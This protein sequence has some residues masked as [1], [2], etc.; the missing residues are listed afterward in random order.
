MSEKPMLEKYDNLADRITGGISEFFKKNILVLALAL[1]AGIYVNG[2]DITN[3]T[4]GIDEELFF[5]SGHFG[6]E[7]LTLDRWGIYLLSRIIPMVWYPF[8]SQLIGI[9]FMILAAILIV[10]KYDKITTSAK[11][12]FCILIAT[13]PIFAYM[14][15]FSIQIAYFGIGVFITV[16]SYRIYCNVI[17]GGGSK[18]YLIPALACM[19]LAVGVYQ[20]FI[21]LFL[22]PLAIDNFIKFINNKITIKQIIIITAYA[23][24]FLLVAIMFNYLIVKILAFQSNGYTSH[25]LYWV[26]RSVIINLGEVF[27]QMYRMMIGIA[28]YPTLTFVATI[29]LFLSIPHIMRIQGDK[30]FK[31]FLRIFFMIFLFAFSGSALA[32]AMGGEL[33]TRVQTS[34]TFFFAGSIFIYY[35]VGSKIE[36]LLICVFVIFSIFYHGSLVT[37]LSFSNY[38]ATEADKVVATRVLDKIYDIAPDFYYGKTPVAFIGGHDYMKR[39]QAI[40]D[41]DVFGGSFWTWDKGNPRRMINFMKVMSGLPMEARLANAEE[42]EK[43]KEYAKNMPAWPSMDSVQLHDGVVI[44]KFAKQSKDSK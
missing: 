32:T 24:L 4:F 23:C 27:V 44:V 26:R 15:A 12:I 2:F 22:M 25:F 16:A 3:V 21:V 11:L 6:K 38:I 35:I 10:S 5:T 31:N 20:S 18:L 40:K 17:A 34:V 33:P 30:S 41:N 1:L 14:S 7:W 29:S 9:I 13:S 39:S 37:R 28:Q 8:I 36:K 42:Y 43:A 19:I